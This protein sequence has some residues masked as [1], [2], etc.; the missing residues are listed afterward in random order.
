VTTL[1]GW[2]LART[3]GLPVRLWLA[4]AAPDLASRLRFLV[5]AET[6]HADLCRLLAAELGETLVPHPVVDARTRRTALACRRR[7]HHGDLVDPSRMDEL[8]RAARA[9][10]LIGLA[11][12]IDRMAGLSGWLASQRTDLAAAV[13]AEHSR[14]LSVPWT[15]LTGSPVGRR[16]LSDGTIAEGKDIAERLRHGA[17]WHGKRLRQRSD[18]LWRMIARGAAKTTPRGWLG[19]VSLVPVGSGL[20][21][22]ITLTAEF[23]AR[24]TEN[25]HSTRLSTANGAE[26]PGDAIVALAPLNWVAGDHLHVWALRTDDPA[27]FRLVRLKMTPALA[28]VHGALR[29]GARPLGDLGV[30]RGF[31]VRLIEMG[32]CE[33]ARPPR[34]RR[35]GWQVADTPATALSEPDSTGFVDV[36][37]RSADTVPASMVAE[38]EVAMQQLQRLNSLMTADEDAP[39]TTTDRIGPEPLRILDLL[40]DDLAEDSPTSRWGSDGKWPEPCQSDS[41][42]ARLLGLLADDMTARPAVDL[43]AELLDRVGA[44]DPVYTWPIDCLVRPIEGAGVVLDVVAPAGMLDARFAAEL[45]RLHGNLPHLDAYRTFL[46]QLDAETGV[47]SVELLAPPLSERAANAVRRPLYPAEWT[48]DP[49]LAAYCGLRPGTARYLP[50]EA[51]TIRRVGDRIVTEVDGAPIRILYHT[52]RVPP[53]PWDSLLSILFT[54]P[55]QFVTRFRR[56][57]HS[58]PGFPGR[59]HVARLT[60]G[61]VIITPAQWR[62][63]LADLWDPADSVLV[64]AGRLARLRDRLGLP[65]WLM[66]CAGPGGA[67]LPADLDSLR[68]LAV[69]EAA[70]ASAADSGGQLVV[71]EM[72][73]APP[74]LPV[75][76]IA[77]G[78]PDQV[79]A[80]LMVRLPHD[81]EVGTL[82]RRTA[83]ALGGTPTGWPARELSAG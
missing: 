39:R 75:R 83:R 17:H 27:R 2:A 9:A 33:A 49:N 16:A 63:E 53:P 23:A 29:S 44:P 43:T 64:R 26:W 5:E 28:A 30:L 12:R 20:S 45:V 18:Y 35:S 60:V 46:E 40:E 73:P 50:L 67:P 24:W 14:L 36:Y 55:N 57:R 7:L 25:I 47:R 38:I 42:Y 65:R 1:G 76:D 15:A 11:D 22:S 52:A 41:A 6:R 51:V 69:F 81:V 77:N 58:L 80:E 54:G 48:G 78:S 37:R 8:S 68:A 21:G 74:E 82:A 79:A 62:V 13:D 10:G 19:H 31:V 56:L 32:V 34:R 71:E 3:A 61:S 70:A 72:V 66:V 59:R 4:A